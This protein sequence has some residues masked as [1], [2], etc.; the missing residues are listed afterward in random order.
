MRHIHNW[1]DA[2]IMEWQWEQEHSPLGIS[3]W[4]W[5]L[6][7]WWKYRPIK[8]YCDSGCGAQMWHNGPATSETYCS[9]SCA[10]YGTGAFD[11]AA[12]DEIP[13]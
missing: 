10:Y 6:R 1:I 8:I 5:C 12:K 3:A 4:W 9:E 13:F 2:R 7:S 11:R